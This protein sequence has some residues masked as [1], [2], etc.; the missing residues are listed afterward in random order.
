MAL[1]DRILA[2]QRQAWMYS[3]GFL[4]VSH[5][6]DEPVDD[7]ACTAVG[8]LCPAS[9]E[10]GFRLF[11]ATAGGSLFFCNAATNA[12]IFV[13]RRGAI[14]DVFQ[15]WGFP[16]YRA[17]DPDV[18]FSAWKRACLAGPV[19]LFYNETCPI[20]AAMAYPACNWTCGFDPRCIWYASHQMDAPSQPQT[21]MT[22]IYPDFLTGELA[23][24]LSYPIYS[25]APRS[26]VAV[27]A[28][29]MFLRDVDAFLAGLP[30]TAVAQT[31]A[32]VLDGPD[33]VVLG[34]NRGCPDA[35]GRASGTPL[36]EACDPAL[37]TL[38]GWLAAHRNLSANASVELAG[39]LWDVL[40]TAV[41]G[42][43]FFVVVGMNQ[44][45]V[46]AV[47][48][49]AKHAA[50]DTLQTLSQQQATQMA[51]EEA[52]ALAQ[53][54]ALAAARV[55]DLMASRQK[56]EDH[57]RAVRNQTATLFN[58]TQQRSA[59]DLQRLIAGELASILKLQDDHIAQVLQGIGVTFGAAVGIFGVILLASA[60]GTWSVT[61]RVSRIAQIMDDVA[62]MRVEELQLREKSS[63][64]EVRRIEAALCV[65]V[66]R[67]A[68]Y[69][70]YMPAGLFQQESKPPRS[71]ACG[72][73]GRLQTLR[74]RSCQSPSQRGSTRRRASSTTSNV[75]TA[76]S[77]ALPI[78]AVPVAS[79]TMRLLRRCVAVMA[80]NVVRFQAEV[81]QR[82]AVHLEAMLNRFIS[83]VHGVASKG[84]GN[85]D[86]IVGDQVLVTFNAHFNCPEP[87]VAACN[88]ALELLGVLKDD[89]PSLAHVQIGLAAGGVSAGHVGYAP[90]KAML[91]VG[92]PMKIASLLAHLSGFE[93][94]VALVCPVLEERI[95]Y[96]YAL[97]PADY[98][99]LPVL[100][101]QNPIYSKSVTIYA[102]QSRIILSDE[103]QE[104]LYEVSAGDLG[105][106]EAMFD[107][108]TKAPS[109]ETAREALDRH[110]DRHP[111]DWL[112][113][114]LLS[115]LPYWQPR[116]GIVLAERPDVPRE[117]RGSPPPSPLL[118]GSA[119]VADR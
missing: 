57:V 108:V 91:A 77:S 87:Y 1:R 52:A 20:G 63:V 41:E 68:E 56:M 94:P 11:I 114:R 72:P 111:G 69:K 51:G 90:F 65:L 66:Q 32:V 76:S 35:M 75:T 79:F 34:T 55:A 88:V 109:L 54:D 67:L 31:V 73:S 39:T 95:K 21:H 38:G 42:L 19:K 85:I 28:T 15:V 12:T 119:F 47:I 105:T 104:W 16:P 6:P 27:A 115:R 82:P 7:A 84:Q 83:A 23:F 62:E 17:T 96:R 97:Q 80:V 118:F 89:Q 101:E 2:I 43:G 117:G 59:V 112:A 22:A 107:G 60:Y 48:A 44:T 64:K 106:W 53:M 102:L 70:S 113:R 98:V 24:S 8:A 14:A 116:V 36:A 3:V 86:A 13:K 100:G 26:L 29:D 71:P 61:N 4:N 93:E 25:N 5:Q 37:Q 103:P 33:L 40:P 50:R 10:L 78:H 58:A 49:A 110:L 92:A 81:A 46:Y 74:K 9:A 30:G 99:F 18:D 45:E